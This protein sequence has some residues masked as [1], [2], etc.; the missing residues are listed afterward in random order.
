MALFLY[1]KP[2]PNLPINDVDPFTLTFDGRLEGRIHKKIYLRNDS[3]ETYYTDI[4][5]ETIDTSGENIVDGSENKFWWKLF[6]GDI[7]P[8]QESWDLIEPG[9]SINISVNLGN[10]LLG[11]IVT[12]ISIW[13]QV[14]V[15]RGLDIQTIKD[16]KFRITATENLI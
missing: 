7:N 14:S 11:D 5:V 12:F 3:V 1:H 6:E 4:V 9:N 13:V 15:P 2:D 10:S 16:V 8:P